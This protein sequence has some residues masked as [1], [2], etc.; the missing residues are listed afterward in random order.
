M[1]AAFFKGQQAEFVNPLLQAQT[2]IL[3]NEAGA[4]TD[5]QVQDALPNGI[6]TDK[7]YGIRKS[8]QDRKL[9]LGLMAPSAV[10]AMPSIAHEGTAAPGEERPTEPATP[11]TEP[12]GSAD[13][14]PKS[15]VQRPGVNRSQRIPGTID[16]TTRMLLDMSQN[17]H[18]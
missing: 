8:E 4:L 11:A 18:S 14:P 15:K 6:T 12:G 13:S 3:L 9:E 16:E 17:G 7:L 10:A 2:L 5:Q 1:A